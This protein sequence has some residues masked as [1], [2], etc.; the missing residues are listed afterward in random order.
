LDI[1]ALE[2]AGDINQLFL[3]IE[4]VPKIAR[5]LMADIDHCEDDG[6]SP[7]QEYGQEFASKL[8]PLW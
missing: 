8:W 5:R 6:C 4:V 7:D 1:A 3:V 2:D